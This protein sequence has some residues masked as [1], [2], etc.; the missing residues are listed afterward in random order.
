V[1][2]P[3]HDVAIE[4]RSRAARVR[5]FACDV[6]GVLTDGGLWFGAEGET[7]K[8]F[9]ARDGLGLKL[10]LEAGIEVAWISGRR[11]DAVR[12]RAAELGIRHVHQGVSDKVARLEAL[13][14]E[15][16]WTFD[17]VAY[18]GDDLPDLALLH[19][20]GFACTVPGAPSALRET[21]HYVSVCGGGRG[22]VREIAELVLR[23]QG[24]WAGVV[25]HHRGQR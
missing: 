5:V 3:S 10:L 13:L 22:A 21:V 6:D 7:W 1:S 15:L 23:A 25:E 24:L 18:V 11:S 2:I 20:V 4:V 16:G 8:R 14:T 19:R 17:Q 12:A 9:D